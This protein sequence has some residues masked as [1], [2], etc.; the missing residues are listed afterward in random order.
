MQQAPF[1]ISE[2]FAE[3][4]LD[5]ILALRDVLQAAC[6]LQ[7]LVDPLMSADASPMLPDV[8]RAGLAAMLRIVNRDFAT[9]LHSLESVLEK[10]GVPVP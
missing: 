2:N 10:A 5:K 9:W 1:T 6:L 8:D 7:E 4:I 3:D